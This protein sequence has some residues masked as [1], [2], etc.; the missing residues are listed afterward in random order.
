MGGHGLDS[1]G[2]AEQQVTSSL[3]K[4]INLRIPYNDGNF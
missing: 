1:F 3:N 2:L 4:T